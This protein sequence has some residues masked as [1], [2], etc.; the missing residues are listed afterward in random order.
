MFRLLKRFAGRFFVIDIVG[1]ID[2]RRA[3][4]GVV[5]Y[6]RWCEGALSRF[7]KLLECGYLHAADE[8]VHRLG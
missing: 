3:A 1:W 5:G 8:H 6:G 4:P 2:S 7:S